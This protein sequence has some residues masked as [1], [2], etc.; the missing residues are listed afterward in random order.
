M[1]NRRP[2]HFLLQ[3]KDKGHPM[4]SLCRHT[5]SR[6]YSSNSFATSAL[7]VGGWSASHPSCL[8]PGQDLLYRMLNGPRVHSGWAWKLL[9]P[10]GFSPW[11]IQPIVSH[12]T[13]H[14]ISSA[15]LSYIPLHSSSNSLFQIFI[16]ITSTSSKYAGLADRG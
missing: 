8:I 10:H 6:K 4:T 15:V 14:S 11:T 12:C 9:L 5:K 13:N 3:C 2:L 16:M 1:S 7:E